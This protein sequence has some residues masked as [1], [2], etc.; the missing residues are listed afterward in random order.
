MATC[1]RTDKLR[2]LHQRIL[3]EQETKGIYVEKC[4]Q[5]FDGFLDTVQFPPSLLHRFNLRVRSEGYTRDNYRWITPSSQKKILPGHYRRQE[6]DAAQKRERRIRRRRAGPQDLLMLEETADGVFVARRG[7]MSAEVDPIPAELWDEIAQTAADDS[8]KQN[9]YRLAQAMPKPAKGGLIAKMH[10]RKLREADLITLADHQ[11]E[12]KRVFD[13]SDDIS[14]YKTFW[15][16]VRTYLYIIDKAFKRMK[17]NYA[18]GQELVSAAYGPFKERV[19]EAMDSFL[20]TWQGMSHEDM[21]DDVRATLT[22][23][24]ENYENLKRHVEQTHTSEDAAKRVGDAIE[25][26]KKVP[27]HFGTCL[28]RLRGELEVELHQ[29]EARSR[30]Y[31]T[32]A[33]I[34]EEAA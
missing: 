13:M 27:L 10:I 32:L 5:T 4:W 16:D 30:M 3:R 24:T 14:P 6:L 34:E 33:K 11:R 25:L 9:P 20:D 26:Y 15:R 2:R 1:K 29:R 17:S 22:R 19:D 28:D 12:F 8:N 21:L 23:E 18:R 31:D 7:R